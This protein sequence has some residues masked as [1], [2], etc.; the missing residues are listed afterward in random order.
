MSEKL[1]QDGLGNLVLPQ[2]Y[3]NPHP[4][5]TRLISDIRNTLNFLFLHQFNDAF[6]KPGFIYLIRQ[7]VNYN[8]VPATLGFIERTG[9]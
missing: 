8:V 5:P 9:P 4:F 2:L 6:N 3:D 7:F 1:V